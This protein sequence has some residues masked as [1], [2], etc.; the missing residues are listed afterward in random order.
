MAH[1]CPLP[2]YFRN[3]YHL[4]ALGCKMATKMKRRYDIDW[5]R[6]LAMC[7]VFVF[8][9][10]RFFDAD[11]WHVKN[12]HTDFWMTVLVS[13]L[14][15][16]I[17]PMFFILSGM[18]AN[19][20]LRV[21][22]GSG[23]YLWG[24]GKRL[25]IPFVF[26]IFTMIPLQVYCERIS[27][28]Q[29]IGTFFD[30]YPHYFDGFYAF[31][32]NFAW[33]GLHLWY[34]LFLFIFTVLTLPL[35]IFLRTEGGQRLIAKADGFFIK[36][37]AIFLI[38]MPVVLLDFGFMPNSPLGV[39]DMG[40]WNLFTYLLLY[41]YGYILSENGRFQ[42]TIQVQRRT[43]LFLGLSS[44]A[45]LYYWLVDVGRPDTNYTVSYLL[46]TIVRCLNSWCLLI[47]SL[48]YGGKYLNFNH[49]LLK[50][51]NELVMPFY[52]LHQTVI[53]AIGFYVVQWDM[54]IVSKYLVIS[55]SSLIV[56]MLFYET[57]KRYNILRFLFGMKPIWFSLEKGA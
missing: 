11:G 34:L 45:I 24:R 44:L 1:D 54:D 47:A 26:G 46:F 4:S 20:G 51:A 35:F 57:I 56:I 43:A 27:H 53:I 19:F 49:V 31:G 5:L 3:I 7:A 42:E 12:T 22:Q 9:C 38:C 33:M 50:S 39:R 15:Q 23:P 8:H 32:G 10:A 14:A 28:Q 17:M 29:F 25:I 37:S 2:D 21:R 40:G 13:A 6:F 30:F 55:S 18:S 52:I 48:G 16:W 36:P 41:I